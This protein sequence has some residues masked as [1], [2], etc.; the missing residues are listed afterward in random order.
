MRKIVE[1]SEKAIYNVTRAFCNF[2]VYY[3]ETFRLI[4]PIE[5]ERDS[6]HLFLSSPQFLS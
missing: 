2:H 1:I 3:F 4:A 6:I 5:T